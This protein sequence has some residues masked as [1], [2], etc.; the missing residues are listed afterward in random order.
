VARDS[1][2]SADDL[3]FTPRE[4]AVLA[5]AVVGITTAKISKDLG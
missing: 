1:R 3:V 5:A 4:H 2:P